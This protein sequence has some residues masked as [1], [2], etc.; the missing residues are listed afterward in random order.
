M[1][2]AWTYFSITPSSARPH[3]YTYSFERSIPF[4]PEIVT[5]VNLEGRLISIV[6]PKGLLDLSYRREE[7]V[8]IKGLLPPARY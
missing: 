1:T 3:S 6:P 2:L 4:V 8:R 7:K 5:R